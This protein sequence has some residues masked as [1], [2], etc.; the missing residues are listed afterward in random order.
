MY[1]RSQRPRDWRMFS[2]HTSML[3]WVSLCAYCLGYI[4]AGQ[5]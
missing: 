5:I 4:K 2:S 3:I 1:A